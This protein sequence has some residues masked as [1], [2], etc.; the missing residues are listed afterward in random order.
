M[1]D[2]WIRGTQVTSDG[3]KKLRRALPECKIRDAAGRAYSA[4]DEEETADRSPRPAP[5][6]E[7]MAQEVEWNLKVLR[8]TSPAR[9]TSRSSKCCA[10]TSPAMIPRRK[11]VMA[12][13]PSGLRRCTQ[14][15]ESDPLFTLLGFLLR[16]PIGREGRIQDRRRSCG[17]RLAAKAAGRR[18]PPRRGRGASRRAN[19]R[20]AGVRLRLGR[21]RTAHDIATAKPLLH[22]RHGRGPEAHPGDLPYSKNST[23]RARR[24]AARASCT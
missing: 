9:P 20:P 22:P 8:R 4:D 13:L 14:E 7:S 23:Y 19:L 3:V 15:M 10:A 12:G 5:F 21:S 16:L 2:L 11:T 6:T 17:A 24:S 1:L 18:F